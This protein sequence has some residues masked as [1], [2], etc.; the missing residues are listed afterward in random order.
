M[1]E[2]LQQLTDDQVALLGCVGALVGSMLLMSLSYHTSRRSKP[3][4]D[5]GTAL[6]PVAQPAAANDEQRRAA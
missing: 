3:V 6:Q 2:L 4:T 5:S 1:A